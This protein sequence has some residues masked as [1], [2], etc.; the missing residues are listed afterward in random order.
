M[1]WTVGFIT[2]FVIGGMTGV[3]L[4]IPAVDFQVHNSLFLIAH[5]HNA[6]IPGVVFGYL[7]GFTYWFPKA[8]G[9]KLHEKLGKY[10][11][12]CW[13]IGFYVAFMPLYALGFMGMTR[14][15]SHY[16]DSNGWQPYLLVAAAGAFIIACGVFFQI[17]QLIVSLKN[18]EKNRDLTG[19][20]WQGRTLEWSIPSPPPFYNFAITPKV[21]GRDAFWIAKEKNETPSLQYEDIHM[22]KNTSVGVFLALFS[23]VLGFAMTW[24][25][26]AIA[27]LSLVAIL[28]TFIRRS[29]D[30]DIDY[31]LTAD[32]VKKLE[33]NSSLQG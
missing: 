33:M 20:P 25:M 24:H 13:F 17:L 9:Y 23:G 2:T 15:L 5:F 30:S 11:F 19:D 10:A 7:A 26:T 14:R 28:I 12:W 8:F 22:P 18:R 16:A 6:I 21:Q 3:L 1:L 29:Y 32:E 27:I 31:I 4:A